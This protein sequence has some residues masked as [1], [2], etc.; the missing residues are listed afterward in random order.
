M[1]TKSDDEKAEHLE[2]LLKNFFEPVKLEGVLGESEPAPFSEAHV[3]I[4]EGEQGG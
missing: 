1:V 4:I 3:T 2:V